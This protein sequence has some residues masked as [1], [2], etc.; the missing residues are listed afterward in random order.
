[1][2]AAL[3]LSYRPISHTAA[4]VAKAPPPKINRRKPA[5]PQAH[6]LKAPR[7]LLGVPVA[8]GAYCLHQ[9]AAMV[10]RS[11]IIHIEK[12]V[13]EGSITGAIPFGPAVE[14]PVLKSS[15]DVQPQDFSARLR[16]VTAPTSFRHEVE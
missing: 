11:M 8:G 4:N 6:V 5:A 10:R 13:S 12:R 16:I 3:P 14:E 15:V 1:M 2:A 7:S 9:I